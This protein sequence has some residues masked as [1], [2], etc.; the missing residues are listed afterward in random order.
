ML[1][2]GPLPT[3]DKC[4]RWP[5]R[6]PGLAHEKKDGGI[7]ERLTATIAWET[8]SS[9]FSLEVNADAQGVSFLKGNKNLVS[10]LGSLIIV[11]SLTLDC[12][13]PAFCYSSIGFEALGLFT[14]GISKWNSKEKKKEMKQ[15]CERK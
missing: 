13:C 8:H 3:H 14:F 7:T 9:F 6:T 11:L 1:L 15:S 12:L 2:L 4:T 10:D 5:V